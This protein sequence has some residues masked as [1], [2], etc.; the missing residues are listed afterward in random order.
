MSLNKG[1]HLS[2]KELA[3]LPV[4]ATP[5]EGHSSALGK[6]VELASDNPVFWCTAQ[7]PVSVSPHKK[8]YWNWQGSDD[9]VQLRTKEKEQVAYCGW[10][11][12]VRLKGGRRT[13]RGETPGAYLYDPSF[14]VHCRGARF[15][16]ASPEG[17]TELAYTDRGS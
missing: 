17:L 10:H 7:R 14:S 3:I 2:N 1:K 15:C 5:W 4:L 6:G 16:L 12:S 13:W 8:N 11:G 9:S